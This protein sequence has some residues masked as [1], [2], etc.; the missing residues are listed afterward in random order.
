MSAD[1]NI[2]KSV[3][4]EVADISMPRPHVV[5]VGAGA[6][7]AAL[8]GGDRNGKRLPVMADFV[9]IKSIA[10]VLS[11]RGISYA[12]R[13]FE[14]LYGELTS[15]P[16]Q[17]ETRQA[18]EAAVFEYFAALALPD[19][20]TLF[21]YLILSL[22]PKDVIA[23]F[24]W[25]PFLIQSA[26]RVGRVGGVPTL[27]FLHGNVLSGYC[28]MDEVFGVRGATC[29]RCGHSF[30]A[31]ALLYPIREKNYA[32][33]PALRSSWAAVRSAL[34]NA[35]MVTIFGYGAPRSD[36][37]AVDLL[38]EAW[39]GWQKREMEQ[40]EI[41]DIRPETEL[42]ETWNRFI[43]THHYEV[44]DDF[45]DSW[46]ARHPRRSGEAYWSQYYDARFIES[47]PAPRTADL[48]MLRKWF[49]PLVEAEK[50]P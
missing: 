14:E 1:L 5:L 43:H 33:S 34:E 21:D 30:T 16:S 38:D 41:I 18:L 2:T 13:N 20:P 26:R 40:F 36:A 15:D 24:N 27:L 48:D 49:A 4:E 47:N 32:S 7:R 35:F 9:E 25:D 22:R 6:S 12:G 46:L 17:E 31:G 23:T 29:S 19:T 39:G 3:A 44:H 45:H 50:K 28:E 11:S 8:P 42:V 10:D 37:G